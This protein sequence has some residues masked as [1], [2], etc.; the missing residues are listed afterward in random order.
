[1]KTELQTVKKQV[2]DRI[3]VSAQNANVSE[4]ARWSQA[5]QEC[6]ELIEAE[7]ILDERIGKFIDTYFRQS[8]ENEVSQN[9]SN[10]KKIS[11]KLEGKL[12]REKWVEKVNSMGI[13]LIGHGKRYF[14]SDGKHI[15]VA[16]ANESDDQKKSDRWFLGLRDETTDIAVLLCKRLDGEIY[17]FILPMSKMDSIWESLSRN[18]GQVKINI[19]KDNNDFLL[20]IP[21]SKPTSILNFVN[22]Y[23]ILKS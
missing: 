8:D 14:T 9:K 22:N 5:A 13:E 6:E 7:K 20:L 4:I 15:G 10:Q 11:H 17:E 3:K 12:E 21:Y 16:F 2:L 1:M 23:S 19:R 18:G